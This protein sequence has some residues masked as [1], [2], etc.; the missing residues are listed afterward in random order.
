MDYSV[1]YYRS[2]IYPDPPETWE[3]L[4]LIPDNLSDKVKDNEN[5]IIVMLVNLMVNNNSYYYY[6]YLLII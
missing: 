6:Y 4:Y 1:L 2:D 5:E 3:D